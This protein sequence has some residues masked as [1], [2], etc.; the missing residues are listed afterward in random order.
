MPVSVVVPAHNEEAVIGRCLTALLDGADEGELD[1]VVVCNG[2]HDRTAEVA[3]QVAPLAIVVEIPVASKVAALNAGDGVARYFPRFYLDADIELSVAAVRQVASVLRQGPVECAAPKPFFDLAG[4]WWPIRAFYDVWKEVPYRSLD[5][6]GSG[7]YALSEQGRARFGE[8]P[9]VT[10]D[11][12]FVQQQFEPAELASVGEARFI[13]HPPRSLRGLVA[14]RARVYR[15]NTELAASGLARVG[16]PPSGAKTVLRLARQPRRAPAIAVYVAVNLL[17]GRRAAGAA[18]PGAAGWE[19]DESARRPQ[20]APRPGQAAPHPGGQGSDDRHEEPGR[21]R[22]TYVASRYPAVSHTFILREVLALR[23]GGTEVETVS[24]HRPG[25]EDLLATVDRQEAGRTWDILPLDKKAFVRAHLRAVCGHPLAY[26]RALAEAVGSS[27]P[28]WRGPLWQLFYF[29]EAVY[30]WDHADRSKVHHLHAHLANVAADVCWLAC[31]FGRGAQ[32]RRDWAW[33]FTMHGPTE[34]YSTERFNLARKVERA[35]A[36]ICISEYTRSQLMY[37]SDAAHWAKLRVVHCGVD[38][39]RYRYSPPPPAEGRLSV[40]CV[41]RLAPQKGL[42]VLV[43]AI[44]ALAGA[45]TDVHLTIAGSGPL[46]ASLRGAAEQAGVADRVSFAGAVGQDDMAAYYARADVFCLPSF[47][48]GLPVVL[49]E[50]MATGRPV[51]ATRIMGVPELVDEG[52]SGFLVAP[53]NVEELAEA[54]RK[55]A[56]SR[57]LRESFGQAGRRKVAEGFDAVRC[58]GQVAEVFDEMVSAAGRRS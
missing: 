43:R 25:P 28:G 7:V 27:P 54:L 4:R 51:V 21:R 35:D 31:S 23:A 9:Q 1:V 8:F 15:G 45:G 32:P 6:V 56:G 41:A 10:A 52:V 18:R 36:V 19:R 50:A 49:M 42:D 58:A 40:L 29:A 11:D 5:M 13:V 26:G 53:G 12:Q 2:C 47:A 22:V 38:L 37:L 34:L 46:E 14:I 44:G 48:E 55:L 33:S 20:A 30:L 24:V 57:A 3:R 17:A 16:P 39:A